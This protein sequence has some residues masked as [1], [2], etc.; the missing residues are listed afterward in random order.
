[1]KYIVSP[2]LAE[3]MKREGIP[4]EEFAVLSRLRSEED[5]RRERLA[6]EQMA[7][8]I[9]RDVEGNYDMATIARRAVG[10]AEFLILEL[11]KPRKVPA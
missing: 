9:A 8:L 2:R 3:L 5:E 4:P 11:E 10:A 6:S 1:M 7:A